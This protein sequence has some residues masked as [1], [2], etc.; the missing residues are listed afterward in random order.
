MNVDPLKVFTDKKVAEL[1]EE[2]NP[3]QYND[4]D[5]PARSMMKEVA[6][7]FYNMSVDEYREVLLNTDHEG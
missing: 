6:D 1:K 5:E 2:W 4:W 7:K 3:K